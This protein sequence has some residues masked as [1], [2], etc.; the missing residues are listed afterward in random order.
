MLKWLTT[1]TYKLWVTPEEDINVP[2]TEFRIEENG[3]LVFYEDD[4]TELTAGPE[5]F[6]AYSEWHS[7]IEI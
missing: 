5:A 2:A 6:A 7:V 4:E 1:L 3:V